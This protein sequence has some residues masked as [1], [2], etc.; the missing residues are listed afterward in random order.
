MKG[1]YNKFLIIII[2]LS[3][4]AA[5]VAAQTGPSAEEAILLTP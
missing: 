2:L 3:G 1:I 5:T 4:M